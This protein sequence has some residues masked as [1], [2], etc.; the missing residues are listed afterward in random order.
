LTEVAATVIPHACR[1]IKTCVAQV[2]KTKTV[3]AIKAAANELRVNELSAGL[4]LSVVE[5]IALS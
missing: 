3:L 5:G 1:S 4:P 2:S